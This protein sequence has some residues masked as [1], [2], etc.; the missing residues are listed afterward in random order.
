VDELIHGTL[1]GYEKHRCRCDECK[2]VWDYYIEEYRKDIFDE[3]KARRKKL[4]IK[5]SRRDYSEVP[6]DGRYY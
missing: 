3:R 4:R 2:G 6:E 5:L 1:D